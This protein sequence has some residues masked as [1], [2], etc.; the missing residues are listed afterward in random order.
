MGQLET[1]KREERE[2]I[3]TPSDGT[4]SRVAMEVITGI[5]GASEQM[6]SKARVFVRGGRI[7][8]N[9]PGHQIRIGSICL[10]ARMILGQF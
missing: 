3:F 8:A 7:A 5:P 4:G 1:Q 6:N 9:S 2:S 10:V